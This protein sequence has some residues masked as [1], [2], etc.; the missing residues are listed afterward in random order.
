[1]KKIN[2]VSSAITALK[3]QNCY[4]SGNVEGSYYVGGIAG[5]AANKNI[6]QCANFGELS[7]DPIVCYALPGSTTNIVDCYYHCKTEN[8]DSIQGRK[9]TEKFSKTF[10][11]E[12]MFWSNSVWNF[13]ED[14][15]PQLK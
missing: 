11:T 9:T 5:I 6:L 10:Y 15:F 14:K 13:F 8:V 2:C 1:M 7:C 3:V 4:N 12:Q